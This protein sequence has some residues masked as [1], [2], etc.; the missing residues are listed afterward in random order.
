MTNQWTLNLSTRMKKFFLAG[1]LALFHFEIYEKNKMKKRKLLSPFSFG[2]LAGF[3][4]FEGWWLFEKFKRSFQSTFSF[5][6][7]ADW[8]ALF[9]VEI[10]DNHPASQLIMEAFIDRYNDPIILHNELN[11]QINDFG[12]YS[13]S[14]ILDISNNFGS[15]IKPLWAM[16]NFGKKFV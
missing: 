5:G 7:L 2:W 14:L 9:R 3:V 10:Y 13:Y 15:K 12:Y 8:L 4:S 11:E 6:W 16:F 1:W